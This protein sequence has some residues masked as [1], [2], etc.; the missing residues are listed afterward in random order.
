MERDAALLLP[1]LTRI[2]EA[3]ERLTP[4][5]PAAIDWSQTLA[6]HWLVGSGGGVLAPL[7]TRTMRLDDLLG[8]E[9][10]KATL[11]ANTRHFLAGLPA[12]HALLWGSRG[13]GKSSLVRALLHDCAGQGL[14]MVE[15]ERSHLCDLPL[16]IAQLRDST[17]R[18]IIYCDDLSF[19]EGDPAYKVLKSVLDGSLDSASEQVLIYA[20]S[21]RRHLLPEYMDDNRA[22]R[23]VGELL[24]ESES[25]EEK[26]SLSDRFGLWLSFYPF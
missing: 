1:T 12:N 15:V 20:T 6:A 19:A 9:R 24:H 10:Q 4:R 23:M 18:F 7:K 14:R 26:I 17:H 3:L 8:V 2:A 5:P 22:A 13:T 11:L 25:S 21:N 16:I